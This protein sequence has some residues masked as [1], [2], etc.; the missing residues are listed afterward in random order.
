MSEISFENLFKILP[1]GV[2]SKYK[3]IGAARTLVIIS[4]CIDLEAN[5]YAWVKLKTLNN[6]IELEIVKKIN[7]IGQ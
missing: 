1:V 7:I 6:T 5:S 3:L 4:L 2:T